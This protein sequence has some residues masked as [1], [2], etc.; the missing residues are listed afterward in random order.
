MGRIHVV[1]ERTCGGLRAQPR[2]CGTGRWQT[3]AGG[4]GDP[5]WR[6]DGRELFYI[7]AASQ[8]TAVMF[9]GTGPGAPKALFPVRVIPPV[10]PYLSSYDVTLDG[11]RF[12][13]KLPVR[14]LTS[15]PLHLLTDWTVTT[16]GRSAAAGVR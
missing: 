3:S 4:G 15:A 14:D 11:Q 9:A 8:L 2:R 12:L 5:R 13:F 16:S 6:G 10:M 7:S 1:R